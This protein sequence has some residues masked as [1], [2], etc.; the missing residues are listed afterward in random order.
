MMTGDQRLT[1]VAVARQLGL[2]E[3]DEG[4][5][6][7]RE[8]ATLDEPTL[9]ERLAHTGVFN[10]VSPADKL[11]IVEALQG[12]GDIV[13]MLGDGVN[14][15]AALKKADIGVAMGRRGTDV[16]KEAADV[17]LADDRF[18]TVAAA[19]EEGRVIFDNIRKFV[20]YLF[21]C[22]L[23]EV[24][25]LLVAGLTG[26]PLPLL[27]LQILWLNLVTD[28]FPALALA[29]EPS[30]GEVMRRPP[31]DPDEAILSPGFL[32]QIA[33]YATLIAGST[34]GAFVVAL[35]RGPQE[36]AI[37]IAFVTL[38]LAQA[39]HLGN[40]RS[41]SAVLSPRR[42]GANRWAL[43]ALALVVGL[44]LAAVYVPALAAILRVVPLAL[45]D[46]SIV[47]PAALLPAVLGQLIRLRRDRNP[48]RA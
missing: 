34:L 48:R 37:T 21:S 30:E 4:A 3:S 44:Q 27:P 5:L 26:L 24:L 32:G 20:F 10:R 35:E 47:L 12:R 15:A 28:T 40:A 41:A 11:R 22:N 7:G 1:A 46:W 8:L 38:A 6:D 39:F 45:A 18:S 29:V 33:L 19:I 36:R 14:D 13:A 43:G 23:A 16:A 31:R 2:T 42:A 17:V 25:I 9:T